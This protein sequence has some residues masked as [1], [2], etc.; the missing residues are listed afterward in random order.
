M[1]SRNKRIEREVYGLCSKCF[2]KSEGLSIPLSSIHNGA[3]IKIAEI[4]GGKRIHQRM[5]DMGLTSGTQ[6][7]VINNHMGLVAL[8]VRGQRLG[9]GRGISKRIFVELID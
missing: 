1:I 6:A 8:A 4:Q 7:Q 5:L 3:T 9:I 2:G